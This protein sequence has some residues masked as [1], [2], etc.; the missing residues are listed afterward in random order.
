LR[1]AK[2]QID[3]G[4]FVRDRDAALAF[5]GGDAGLP[6]DHM[7]K[8][9]GGIQQHR[10]IANSS[11]VKLNHSRDPLAV[12]PPAGWRELTIAREGLATP[13]RMVDPDGTPL[14]LVPPG[15][16]GIEGIGLR[17]V[18]N[19]VEASGRFYRDVMQL[20]SVGP[21]VY[22]CGSSV[23][24][25][26]PGKVDRATNWKGPGFRYITVQVFDCVA[27]HDGVLARGGEEGQPPTVL[28]DTVRYS[29]VRDPDGNFIEISQKTT[30][31]GTAL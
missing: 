22:R 3:I 24:R 12:L 9:G 17:V 31:T 8:L 27:E 23:L 1:L 15:V 2:P 4:L 16:D 14:V 21:H 28:G 6:F 10:F 20:E 25:L 13:Q 7:A 19:D 11:V 5:W 18:A 30:F 26:E 29:F